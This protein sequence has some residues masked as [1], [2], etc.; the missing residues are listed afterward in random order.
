MKS[1]SPWF[2]ITTI[3]IMFVLMVASQIGVEVLLGKEAHVSSK[4]VLMKVVA[5]IT[6]GLVILFFVRR[7]SRKTKTPILKRL[8]LVKPNI[9]ILDF[10]AF[11]FGS[12]AVALMAE[13]LVTTIIDFIPF[14]EPEENTKML[15]FLEQLTTRWGILFILVVA[16]AP[17]FIEEIAYRGFL[18]RGLLK[19]YSPVVSIAISSFIFGLAH[20]TFEQIM[21]TSIMGLWLGIIAWRVNSIWPTILCHICI[22]GMFSLHMVG[23][24]LWG[25]PETL[26]IIYK[27]IFAIV[28]VYS[29]KILIQKKTNINLFRI[30]Y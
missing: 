24:Q 12:I 15:Q 3:L 1:V 6:G 17:G 7:E 18:Q 14:Y 22:N 5:H 8:G 20:I 9:S 30:S 16:I 2:L 26:P 13:Y 11:A 10:L 4:A 21:F 19:R 28:F 29:V 25:F 27:I 23:K